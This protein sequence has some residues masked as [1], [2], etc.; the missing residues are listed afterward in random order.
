MR[1]W[2][3]AVTRIELEG[4]CRKRRHGT[5]SRHFVHAL[6]EDDENAAPMYEYTYIGQ[7]TNAVAD[8]NANS[9]GVSEDERGGI[10]PLERQRA[11]CWRAQRSSHEA[12]NDCRRR[13]P[14]PYRSPVRYGD[15]N[16]SRL[17]V[18]KG[19]RHVV[20]SH[21]RGPP[22]GFGEGDVERRHI[23]LRLRSGGIYRREEKPGRLRAAGLGR[24]PAGDNTLFDTASTSGIL[25]VVRLRIS[26]DGVLVISHTSWRSISRGRLQEDGYHCLQ[27]P[28]I[29]VSKTLV[30]G[31]LSGAYLHRRGATAEKGARQ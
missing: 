6:V 23:R 19:K 29:T 12:G 7:A 5:R 8:P 15:S 10:K 9:A 3:Q 25:S 17:V 27:C 26:N 22:L 31:R 11:V 20:R 14:V 30:D 1:D 16:R 28:R 2:D 4:G 24:A 13:M 18:H 21:A